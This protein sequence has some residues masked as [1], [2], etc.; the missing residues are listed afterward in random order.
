MVKKKG[1]LETKLEPRYLPLLVGEAR[2]LE[3]VRGWEEEDDKKLSLLRDELGVSDGPN[4]HYELA[5]ALARKYVA[6]FQQKRPTRK[7]TDLVRGLLVAE[8]KRLLKENKKLPGH[9]VTWAANQLARRSEW[10]DFLSGGKNPGEALRNS[11]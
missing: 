1:P 3:F 9:S 7:W 2:Q 6:G 5:L 8:V 4:Q 11:L 10:A